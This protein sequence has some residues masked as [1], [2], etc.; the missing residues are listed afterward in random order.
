MHFIDSL[1]KNNLTKRNTMTGKAKKKKLQSLIAT[2][3][4]NLKHPHDDILVFGDLFYPFEGSDFVEKLL[5]RSK[6]SMLF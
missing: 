2:V 1:R 4:I 5:G 3:F 6:L